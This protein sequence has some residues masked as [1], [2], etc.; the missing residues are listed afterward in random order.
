MNSEQHEIDMSPPAW[1]SAFVADLTSLGY[2]GTEKTASLLGDQMDPALTARAI[3][4]L[5]NAKLKPQAPEGVPH[6]SQEVLLVLQHLR[7]RPSEARSALKRHSLR[8]DKALASVAFA[9][10]YSLHSDAKAAYTKGEIDIAV[11]RFRRATAEFRFAIESGRLSSK[12]T[13][14]ATGMYA[15]GTAMTARWIGLPAAT[16]YQALTYS[17]NSM[18]LGNVKREALAYRMELVTQAYDQTGEAGHLAEGLRLASRHP[19]LA[20]GS[21]LAQAELALRLALTL[22]PKNKYWLRRMRRLLDEFKAASRVD[23]ARHEIVRALLD[24]TEKHP[25]L[26]PPRSAS[27]PRGLLSLMATAPSSRLWSAIRDI[28]GRLSLLRTRAAPAAIFAAQF[29]RKI[30]EGPAGLVE[31]MDVQNY[32]EMTEWLARSI[33][34]RHLQLE[35]ADAK[36]H[37]AMRDAR[38]GEAV[39]ARNQFAALAGGHPSWPMPHVG[40]ARARELLGEREAANAEWLTAARLALGAGEYTRAPLGGRKVFAMADARG[41]LADTLVFK[42][43]TKTRA[44]HEAAMLSALRDE[45]ARTSTGNRFEA[46]RSLAIVALGPDECVHVTQRSAGRVLADLA[47]VDLDSSLEAITELLAMYHR[48]AG[49]VQPGE[50]GWKRLKRDVRLWAKTLFTASQVDLFMGR[51]KKVYPSDLQLVRKRDGHAANWIVDPAGRVVAIDFEASEFLPIGCDLAQLIEDRALIPPTGD[52]WERRMVLFRTYLKHLGVTVPEEKHTAAYG[53]FAV[54]RA[55][56][57]GTE[58]AAG[59]RFHRHA[60]SVCEMV[61]ERANG[62]LRE[63]AI[64]LQL[65]LAH[66][67][68]SGDTRAVRS[69]AHVRLSRGMA[70]LLRHQGPSQGVAVDEQGFAS[71]EAVAA[72]IHAEPC[73]L[74]AVAAH[75]AEPRFQVSEARIRALYGHSLPVEMDSGLRIGRPRALYHGTSWSVLDEIV[76]QGLLPLKRQKVHLTSSSSEAIE[77]GRRKG[78]P[79]VLRVEADDALPAADGIWVT[80][81]VAADHL[82][83]VNP[84]LEDGRA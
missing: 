49:S 24:I 5:W 45:I 10:G 16:L 50:S 2:V 39:K 55:L 7:H 21:E 81:K 13:S 6:P 19:D 79:I 83:V 4:A 22:P 35:A 78:E 25:D 58:T 59:K 8:F 26:V 38:S 32:V 20:P 77:V 44:E 36:L 1:V 37:V 40:L 23:E 27:V 51:M 70:T 72:A 41:V 82:A 76:C 75:P 84:F 48:V 28:V 71:I 74:L 63:L 57:L 54:A 47:E 42:P 3:A 62:E 30:I 69:H 67:D 61:A 80:R 17:S 52:G 46:P 14:I 60:R 31:A 64:E 34:S 11:A 66:V 53:W 9:A 43:S 56:R 15:S 33:P 68:T 73:E 65:A 18:A 29:L 12:H